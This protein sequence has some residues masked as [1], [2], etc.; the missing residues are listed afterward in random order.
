MLRITA[1]VKLAFL[2][3]AGF[4]VVS[5]VLAARYHKGLDLETGA[6]LILLQ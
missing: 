4:L 3:W 2:P 6:A 5:R 1:N